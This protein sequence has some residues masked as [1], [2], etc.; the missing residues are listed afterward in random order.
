MA[1]NGDYI[2]NLPKDT[3]NADYEKQKPVIDTVFG[4]NETLFKKA[5]KELSNSILIAVLFILFTLPQIDTLILKNIPNSNNSIVMYA[6]KC[7]FIIVL[8]YLCR[9]V[10]FVKS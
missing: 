7:F 2:E 9:N 4:E 6:V 1:L 10:Q 8:Y 5:M 3:K